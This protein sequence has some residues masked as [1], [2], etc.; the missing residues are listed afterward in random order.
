MASGPKQVL[1]ISLH[2]QP[3][4]DE[5]YAPLLTA[6]RA[7][8]TFN[9]AEDA[10]AAIEMLSS[11]PKPTAVL[12]TDEALTVWENKHVWEAVLDYVRQGGTAVV[13]GLFGSFV[14]P[15]R[16]KPFFARASLSWEV[17]WKVGLRW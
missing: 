13:M 9:R 4:F 10:R 17:A 3:W 16:I 2:Q 5:R 15:D 14:R 12:V 7:R 8:A 11:S 1:A 6:I